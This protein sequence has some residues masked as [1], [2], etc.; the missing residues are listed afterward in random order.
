MI[1]KD[2]ENLAEQNENFRKVI[3]TGS[4]SQI[5]LMSIPQ[6]QDIGDEVH[7]DID[8][9]LVIVEGDA[10]VII[11]GSEEPA[12]EDD[13][14]VVPAGAQHNV[15]NT[16]DQDLKLY[17]MYAPSEHPDGTIHATKAEADEAE[18]HH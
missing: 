8:Q 9:I 17:T 14:I 18:H 2:I 13:M 7:S 16:G 6:G 1:F 11:D 4:N 5:V 15:I 3:F 12:G 10:K